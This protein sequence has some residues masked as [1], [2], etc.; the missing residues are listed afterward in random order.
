MNL[1]LL[2]LGNC[3]CGGMTCLNLHAVY[4]WIVLKKHDW[5]LL[6][7]VICLVERHVLKRSSW[8][9]EASEMT[10]TYMYVL[11]SMKG[12]FKNKMKFTHFN[13]CWYGK[14]PLVWLLAMVQSFEQLVRTIQTLQHKCCQLGAVM[15]LMDCCCFF[16]S[17]DRNSGAYSRGISVSWRT[18]VLCRR[19]KKP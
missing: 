14:L 12:I 9:V 13:F 5:L 3:Q 4:L 18:V 17:S 6:C 10:T 2:S 1:V 7:E 16:L 15:M 8:L 11:Y 19:K